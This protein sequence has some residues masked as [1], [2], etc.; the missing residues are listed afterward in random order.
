MEK[1]N[2]KALIESVVQDLIE[3]Q[4]L[5]SILLKVQAIAHYLHN[6]Q[7][8]LWLKNETKGDYQKVD[9]LPDYRKSTCEIFANIVTPTGMWQKYRIPLDQFNQK[10]RTILGTVLFYDSIYEIEKLSLEKNDNLRVYLSGAAYNTINNIL[11]YGYVQSAWQI[12]SPRV[13]TAIIESIKSRLLEFFLE[14]DSQ[15]NNEINFDVMAK[16][17]DIDNLVTQIINPGVVATGNSHISI[18]DT[19]VVAGKGNQITQLV[20]ENINSLC[21]EI[22]NCIQ[23]LNRKEDIEDIQLQLKI[24]QSQLSRTEPKSSILKVAFSTIKEILIGVVGNQATPYVIQGISNIL[25]I[26]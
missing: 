20:R 24:I 18:S 10:E 26:I 11:Q 9:E 7:F 5:T 25:G 4:P 1:L 12:I 19:I 21:Q 17:N 23:T 3:N 14:I 6:E 2:V 13:F 15:F 22:N 16:R 8:S